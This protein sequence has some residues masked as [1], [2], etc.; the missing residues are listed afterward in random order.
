[1]TA[2][3]EVASFAGIGQYVVMAALIAVDA[4]EPLMKVTAV[5]KSNK[6]KRDEYSGGTTERSLSMTG[7]YLDM[8]R[9]VLILCANGCYQDQFKS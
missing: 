5:E 9:Y 1:M 7:A 4:R 6:N 3:T 2:R 8:S